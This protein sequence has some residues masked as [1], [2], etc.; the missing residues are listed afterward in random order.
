MEKTKIIEDNVIIKTKSIDN[1]IKC[2]TDIE[3][4]TK[5]D[6]TPINYNQMKTRKNLEN[7]EERLERVLHHPDWFLD[8]PE[9]KHIPKTYADYNTYEENNKLRGNEMIDFEIQNNDRMYDE[10]NK[11]SEENL[12]YERKGPVDLKEDKA[13]Q[14]E[15]DNIINQIRKEDRTGKSV[16]TKRNHHE[17][18][19]VRKYDNSN[20]KPEEELKGTRIRTDEKGKQYYYHK[21]N[22]RE[23]KYNKEW[24][25]SKVVRTTRICY[26]CDEEGHIAKFCTEKENRTC[27]ICKKRGHIA[28]DCRYKTIE[29]PGS[30]NVEVLTRLFTDILQQLSQ[31][32]NN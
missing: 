31:P 19:E 32:K 21:E 29:K 2:D 8:S 28:Q 11:N 9:Q 18:I 27:F 17:D 3:K 5:Q 14:K 22:T 6:I 1:R 4:N 16:N 7:T 30:K 20:R 10:K 15:T 25:E 26:R 13:R 24:S 23:Q 12:A